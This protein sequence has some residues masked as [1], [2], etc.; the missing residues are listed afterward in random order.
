MKVLIIRWHHFC[1][2]QGLLSQVPTARLFTYDM[3][4]I[5]QDVWIE[6]SVRDI[7]MSHSVKE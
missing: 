2:L 6:D 5:F 1:F 4:K 7:K 3:E